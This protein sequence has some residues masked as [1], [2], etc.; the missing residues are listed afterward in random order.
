MTW[1]TAAAD[2]KLALVRDINRIERVYRLNPD[3]SAIETL[4]LPFYGNARLVSAAKPAVKGPPLCYV[5]LAAEL[6]PLDG[7]VANIHHLNVEAPLALDPVNAAA[8][9]KFYFHF[10]NAGWLESAL[11]SPQH[12]A[13]T[14]RGRL[15]QR[16]GAFDLDISLSPRGEVAVQHKEKAPG[17]G[18][19]PPAVFSF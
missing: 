8:Y 5:R 6:V 13:F 10:T 4:A 15:V 19:P 18:A 1:K 7:S 9:L 17:A 2:E 3:E 12:G 11:V 14:A 16:D